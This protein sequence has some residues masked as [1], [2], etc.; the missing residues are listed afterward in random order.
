M[1]ITVN[2]YSYL[3]YYLPDAEKLFK[4]KEWEVPEG[5]TIKTVVERLKLPKE[6]RVSV[7]LNNNSVDQ[8]TSLKEGDVI[9][10][11]PQITNDECEHAVNLGAHSQFV[12]RH[13]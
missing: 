7:L 13:S 10:I 6:I 8:M 9:H 11:L 12:I 1:R 4:E 2:I 3:R 5:S